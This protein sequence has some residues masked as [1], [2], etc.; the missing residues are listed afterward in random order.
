VTPRRLRWLYSAQGVATGLLV[1]FLVP[2]LDERGLSPA[3]L[4]LV[5]GASGLLSLVAYPLWGMLGDGRLGRPRTLALAAVTAA[6][7]GAWILAA[8]SD[9]VTLS[10]SLSVAYIG[11]LAFGP[12]TD[13]MALAALADERTAY[14]RLR[15]WASLG[16][17]A[18]AITA[19]L[20]WS[21]VGATGVYAAF[22]AAA[23]AVV[24][25]ALAGGPS[26]A[27]Q[28]PAP[29]RAQA[30][31]TGSTGQGSTVAGREPDHRASRSPGVGLRQGWRVMLGS[32]VLLG[33]LLGFFIA[34]IGEHATWRF[35]SLRILDQGG[36]V[37]LVGVAAALP[38]LVEVPVFSASRRVA[39]RL[40]LRLVFVAGVVLT[41][42]LTLLIA[43]A[44]EAWMVAALRMLDGGSYAL[45][46]VGMVL[47]VGALL[48][49]RYHALGQSLAWLVAMG[50]AP[51]VGDALG[52]LVYDTLGST[53]LF[54]SAGLLS[55]VGAAVAYAALGGP[56]FRRAGPGVAR[57]SP[58]A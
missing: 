3:E 21:V 35:V 12:L 51:I 53:L 27:G 29:D 26:T 10:L 36:G 9:P 48:P 18:S 16:W 28:R 31:E 33:F 49:L 23:T 54:I 34:A 57:A 42:L 32:R 17:A 46:Y 39:D 15:A 8:G 7:G 5:L 37:L 19:G 47:I 1:P 30:P 25:T 4:G 52:G 50:F 45:R 2:L 55:L 11:I 13:S 20:A 56:A 40:G 14:G 22:V 6:G 44:P 58:T 43:V 38:A 41:S 24:I